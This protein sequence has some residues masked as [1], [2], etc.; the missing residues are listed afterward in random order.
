MSHCHPGQPFW[1]HQCL[2]KLYSKADMKWQMLSTLY[3]ELGWYHSS[4]NTEIFNKENTIR[5]RLYLKYSTFSKLKELK[6]VAFLTECILKIKQLTRCCFWEKHMSPLPVC[7]VCL[8]LQS[9]KFEDCG[10]NSTQVIE[11]TNFT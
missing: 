9:S 1:V 7:C 3:Q 2:C 8:S 5:M 10:S 11:Q 6:N 4:W